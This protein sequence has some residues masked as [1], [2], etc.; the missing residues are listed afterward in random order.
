MTPHTPYEDVDEP[1]NVQAEASPLDSQLKSLESL[2]KEMAAVR[3]LQ[4]DDIRVKT[5]ALAQQYTGT[6]DPTVYGILQVL[7]LFTSPMEA[8]EQ[9]RTAA[10]SCGTI[11]NLRAQLNG[12]LEPQRLLLFGLFETMV[13]CLQVPEVHEQPLPTRPDRRYSF[14]KRVSAQSLETHFSG[15]KLCE[16]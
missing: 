16:R 4:P 5:T 1:G 7:A 2:A 14:T 15:P 11:C 3:S 9:V 13:I 10:A 12:F 8:N 6:L